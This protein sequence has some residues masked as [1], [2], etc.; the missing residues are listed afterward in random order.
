MQNYFNKTWCLKRKTGGKGEHIAD[1]F[2]KDPEPWHLYVCDIIIVI[3]YIL[4]GI[5]KS[6]PILKVWP[7][8]NPF[9]IYCGAV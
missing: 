4:K 3:E 6:N 8:K 1:N 9:D 5:N 2:H 7:V